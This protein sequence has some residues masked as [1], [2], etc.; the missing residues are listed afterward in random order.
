MSGLIAGWQSGIAGVI[1]TLLIAG[2]E[3]F[4]HARKRTPGA[5]GPVGKLILT[6]LYDRATSQV[7]LRFVAGATTTALGG[8]VE[9]HTDPGTV[10]YTHENRAYGQLRRPRRSV[11]HQRGQYVAEGGVHTNSIESI[12]ALFKRSYRG[13]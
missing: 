4:K 7:A 3:R 5:R 12:W 6:G 13:T 2:I 10:V 1:W 11:V 9:A 8:F